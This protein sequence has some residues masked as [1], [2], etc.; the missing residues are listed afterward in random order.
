MDD[1]H[2]SSVTKFV[3]EKKNNGAKGG[4]EGNSGT[5][6]ILSALA[7]KSA[8]LEKS[9]FRKGIFPFLSFFFFFFFFFAVFGFKISFGCPPFYPPEMSSSPRRGFL[10]SF[11]FHRWCTAAMYFEIQSSSERFPPP[12]P[13]AHPPPSHLP[14]LSFSHM[15][16]LTWVVAGWR[17]DHNP[18]SQPDW[19]PI[20]T[21]QQQQQQIVGFFANTTSFL[22]S[23]HCVRLRPWQLSSL[24]AHWLSPWPDDSR[25]Q[26][27]GEVGRGGGRLAGRAS[28]VWTGRLWTQLL[29]INCGGGE[30][31]M[32]LCGRKLSFVVRNWGLF[33]SCFGSFI[34]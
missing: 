33:C 24:S 9:Y 2:F 16:L 28:W 34:N 1:S 32:I 8:P 7:R 10:S 25:D 20:V 3:G 22:P 5:W 11:E 31:R 27:W 23:S 26:I 15:L 21:I 6:N 18:S 4:G 17:T 29:L 30:L 13:P 19:I 12:P 14:D